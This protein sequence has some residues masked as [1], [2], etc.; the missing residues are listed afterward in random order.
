[1]LN[2]YILRNIILASWYNT[3]KYDTITEETKKKTLLQET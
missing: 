1:M 2:T 3:I